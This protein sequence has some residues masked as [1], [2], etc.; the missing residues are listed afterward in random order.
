MFRSVLLA[1]RARRVRRLGKLGAG[2][3][4]GAVCW[5]RGA[6]RGLV[7]PPLFLWR[8]LMDRVF[9]VFALRFRCRSRK[10]APE[11]IGGKGFRRVEDGQGRDAGWAERGCPAWLRFS[12]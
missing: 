6:A 7:G 9:G 11:K 5:R 10:F 3:V 12:S 8:V 4:H 2:P 1:E